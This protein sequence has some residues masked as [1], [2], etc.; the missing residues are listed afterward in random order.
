MKTKQKSERNVSLLRLVRAM[1]HVKL[2]WLLVLAYIAVMLVMP[3][4]NIFAAN[5]MG[6]LIDA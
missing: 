3:L 4:A 1:R 5:A 6:D 2:P